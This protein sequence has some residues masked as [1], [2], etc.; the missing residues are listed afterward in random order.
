MTPTQRLY[1]SV[2]VPRSL[3]VHAHN[4]LDMLAEK[5][6]DDA[7]TLTTPEPDP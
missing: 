5:A 2:Q 1:A 7:S 3:L 6:P 4:D